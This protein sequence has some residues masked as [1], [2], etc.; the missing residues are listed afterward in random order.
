MKKAIIVASFGTSYQEPRRNS[1]EAIENLI[2]KNFIEYDVFRAFTSHMVIRKIY[3]TSSEKILTLEETLEELLVASYDEIIIQ[4]THMIPG[5]EFDYLEKVR[6]EYEEKFN[7]IKLGRPIFYFKGQ[8]LIPDDY[9]LFIDSIEDILKTNENVILVGHGTNHTSS[10]VYSCLQLS[11]EDK[12]FYNV[13]VGTI[14]GYPSIES[15]INKLKKN[16]IKEVVLMPLMVVAGD[17]AINDIGSDEED[18]WKSILENE[19]IKVRLF[20]K[21]LGEIEK[22]RYLYVNRVMDIIN[23]RYMGVGKT[24]KGK[25]YENSNDFIKL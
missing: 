13:L 14:E 17:H 11:L 1:L 25:R 2:Q 7:S 20:L 24:K 23:N 21:G 8:D 18:S 19:D 10:A 3:K 15:V 9:N 22:F 5:E 4:P 16:K 12:G 6:K